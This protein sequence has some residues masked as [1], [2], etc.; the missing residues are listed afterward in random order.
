MQKPLVNNRFLTKKWRDN[1]TSG[2]YNKIIETRR[3]IKTGCP[4]SFDFRKNHIPDQTL[5]GKIYLKII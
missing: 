5:N 4:E 1:D 3:E 2:L